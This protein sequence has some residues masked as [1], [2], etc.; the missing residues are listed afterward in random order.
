MNIYCK[1][2]VYL[3]DLLRMSYW[4]AFAPMCINA[5]FAIISLHLFLLES[6]MI[7]FGNR[8]PREVNAIINVF[9]ISKFA[10]S[11]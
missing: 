7:S 10:Q 11:T 3:P 2:S 1:Y 6:E 8:L 4:I 9:L 5:T